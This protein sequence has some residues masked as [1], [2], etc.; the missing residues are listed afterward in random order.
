MHQHLAP[1]LSGCSSSP[2][3]FLDGKRACGGRGRGSNKSKKERA[4]EP[5]EVSQ[6]SEA[7]SEK[8]TKS[9]LL[10]PKMGIIVNMLPA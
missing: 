4:C 5:M 10:P 1:S 9:G 6:P 2:S 7:T 3:I 8:T